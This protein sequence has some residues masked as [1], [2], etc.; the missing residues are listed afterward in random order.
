MS[1]PAKK[2]SAALSATAGSWIYTNWFGLALEPFSLTPDTAFFYR[3]ASA[4]MALNTLLFATGIGEGFIKIVGE[5]G[6]GKTLLCRQFLKALDGAN[7]ATAY[8]PNP[9]VEPMTLLLAIA[10]ELG[11]SYPE[12]PTQHQLLKALTRYLMA[13]YARERRAVVVCLDEAHAL[14]P[15]TLEAL[16]LLSNLETSR[17]KLM[18]LVLFGQPELDVRLEQTNVRQL[19]QRI[20]FAAR[21]DALTRIDTAAYMAH[22]LR[23]AGHDDG[24]TLFTPRACDGLHHASGGTPRLINILAHKALLAA[25]GQGARVIDYRHVLLACAD[26]EAARPLPG[27]AGL[28][29]SHWGTRVLQA[30]GIKR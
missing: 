7:Y 9:Y 25:F 16:R 22:R 30:L 11:V 24:R 18:Q 20:A 5:V 28:E 26:T 14:P 6:C 23:V 27:L 21:L 17:R 10:D 19:K 12:G 4:H 8:I 2:P 15:E 29:I 13:T 1:Y 3:H